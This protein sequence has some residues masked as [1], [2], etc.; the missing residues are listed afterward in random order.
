MII[1]Q[2]PT[3]I[4]HFTFN[5]Y[6]FS[7]NIIQKRYTSLTPHS[8][9]TS[10]ISQKIHL[11]L[12]IYNKRIWMISFKTIYLIRYFIYNYLCNTIYDALFEIRLWGNWRHKYITKMMCCESW[13]KKIINKELHIFTDVLGISE[14]HWKSIFAKFRNNFRTRW[15]IRHIGNS[16]LLWNFCRVP[17][18][19]GTKK[20][21]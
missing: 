16:K 6:V 3:Q 9:Y 5:I 17:K 20:L 8:L 15:G 14:A 21:K 4:S 10:F 19:E 13:R 18:N 7:V 2:S 12:N 1:F 11:Y